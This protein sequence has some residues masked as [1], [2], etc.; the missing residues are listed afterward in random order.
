MSDILG[1]GLKDY[2]NGNYT[3]NIITESTISEEDELP[4]PYLF[5]S[6]AEMPKIE[7]IALS[8]CKGNILDIGCGSGSH[9]LYLQNNKNLNI[10]AIDISKGATEVAKLRGVKNVYNKN[11]FEIKEKYDTLLILMNGIGICG[12]LDRINVFLQHLKSILNKDGQILLDSSDISYMF[13]KDE[14]GGF[15]V[16]PNEYYGEVEFTMSYKGNKSKVFDWLYLDFNTL[17]NACHANGLICELILEGDHY[18]FLV[19]IT[20]KKN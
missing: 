3:E 18:D 9:S 5:R 14:E 16:N 8:I 12:K 1:N 4:L 2:Y 7:Q 10:N 15:W 20:N 6:F 17:L 19:K 11:L 13:E